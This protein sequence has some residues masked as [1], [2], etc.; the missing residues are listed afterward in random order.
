MATAAT[1][2]VAVLMFTL[3]FAVIDKVLPAVRPSG[4]DVLVGAFITA[5]LSALEQA[6]LGVDLADV[7]RGSLFGAVG[8]LMAVLLWMY[9]STQMMF[10]GAQVAWCTRN[11]TGRVREGRTASTSRGHAVARH[12]SMQGA[13]A[14]G[15]TS[16]PLAADRLSTTIA[17]HESLTKTPSMRGT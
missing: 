14:C 11:G 17:E 9:S 5:L 15:G 6:A 12:L 8:S 16:A 3:A 10:L 4:R 2:S 1:F 7:S 13:L